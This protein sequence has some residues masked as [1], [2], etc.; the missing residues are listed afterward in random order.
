MILCLADGAG[1]RRLGLHI[2]GLLLLMTAA[3]AQQEPSIAYRLQYAAAGDRRVQ[4]TLT[5]PEPVS[6]NVSFVM[7]R[8]YPGGYNLVPYDS[9]VE[10]LRASSETGKL[11]KVEKE[12]EGPRWRL[13]AGRESL[14]RIDYDIDVERMERE[15]AAS[16]DTSKVRSGYLG[17]LGYS[18]FGYIDGLQHRRIKL[19]V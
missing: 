19:D 14:R 2:V 16:I 11:L 7:P 9:F 15:L 5:L 17:I 12:A 4:I 8:N 3:N 6:E 18:V 10:N 13:Q 1:A